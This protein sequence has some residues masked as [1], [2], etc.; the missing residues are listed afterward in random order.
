MS[1]YHTDFDKFGENSQFAIVDSYHA[2]ISHLVRNHLDDSC[3]SWPDSTRL[4]ANEKFRYLCETLMK[5]NYG[6]RLTDG[7]RELAQQNSRLLKSR[8]AGLSLDDINGLRN[9]LSA[10]HV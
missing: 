2:A 5:Y 9:G 3:E 6:S 1:A 8:G 10:T 7:L 4:V